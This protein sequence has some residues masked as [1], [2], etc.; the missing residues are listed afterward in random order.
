MASVRCGLYE[1]RRVND[2]ENTQLVEHKTSAARSQIHRVQGPA[3]VTLLAMVASGQ[4]SSRHVRRSVAKSAGDHERKSRAFNVLQTKSFQAYAQGNAGAKKW[5]D[6]L[7]LKKFYKT[8]F[9]T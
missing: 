9:Q 3:Q 6:F 2:R 7:L 4:K 5:L 8:L 1:T